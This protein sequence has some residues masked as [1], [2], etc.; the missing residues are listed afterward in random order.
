MARHVENI[1]FGRSVANIRDARVERKESIEVNG[2]RIDCY[3]VRAEYPRTPGF[4]GSTIGIRTVWLEVDQNLIWRDTWEGQVPVPN[5]ASAAHV[6]V[7]YSYSQLEFDKELSADLFTF[8]PPEGSVQA[9]PPAAPKMFYPP[10]APGGGPL[11][12]MP[13]GSNG[14]PFGI[15]QP[16]VIHKVDPEYSEEA[17]KAQYSGTV[18]LSVI[19][20]T[21]G[22]P[23]DI[24]VIRK[25][26][27]G[28]DEKAVEAVQ[29]WKFRPAMKGATPVNVRA[30][31][32]VNFKLYGPAWE[33]QGVRFQPAAGIQGPSLRSDAGTPWN[34][35]CARKGTV[36]V[37][38]TVGIDGQ[39]SNP[40]V[41]QTTNVLAN[42]SA[43]DTIMTLRFS[44]ALQD[45]KAVPGEGEVE[46]SCAD[47]V[48]EPALRAPPPPPA[49]TGGIL[50]GM[51]GNAPGANPGGSFVAPEGF[52]P[53]PGQ[54]YVPGNV[55]QAN[56]THEETPGY[57]PAAKAAHVQGNVIMKAIIGTDGTV[58]ELSLVSGPPLLVQAAMDTVKKW[59]YKPTL[60]NGHAVEV[61]TRL[62][63]KFAVT[64]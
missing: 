12:S 33:I 9:T 34:R 32:E 2:R 28:L 4:P 49:M 23:R 21:Q 26:G 60:L 19:V 62:E 25:L 54:V 27:M 13:A 29:K 48:L 14:N 3:V 22:N 51:T 40:K 42:E 47:R 6:R 35:S 59:V 53:G 20:D 15:S 5:G 8:H 45:G 57:P 56:L 11:A 30:T 37:G 46:L 31:V 58:K 52:Q 38:L 7:D 64:E 43:L 63:L 41:L 10:G 18:L 55:M 16:A 17:R 44:P 1:V 24:R 50:G 36:T 39:P 61:I